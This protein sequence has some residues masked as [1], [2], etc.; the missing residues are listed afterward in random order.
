[1]P[2]R[3]GRFQSWVWKMAWRDSRRSRRRLVLYSASIVMGIAA[4]VAIG[5]F[6]RALRT[7]MEQQAKALLGADLEITSRQPLSV[8]AQTFLRSLGG[9]QA[10][11]T[12]FTSMVQFPTSGATRLV[13]VR[14]LAGGFPFY[15]VMETAP[16]EAVTQFRN[17]GGAL[18]EENLLTQFGA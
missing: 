10:R 9:E 6:G 3:P 4:L 12:S 14:A 8:E 5:S 7:A 17:G 1:M 16:A 11:E 2:A 13:Q 15:G 18:V